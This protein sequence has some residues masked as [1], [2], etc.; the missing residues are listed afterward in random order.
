MLTN[1]VIDAFETGAT[2][3]SLARYNL[4]GINYLTPQQCKPISD[5]LIAVI[6][7]LS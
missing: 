2:D 4:S 3:V 1:A 6:K 7:S 5:A